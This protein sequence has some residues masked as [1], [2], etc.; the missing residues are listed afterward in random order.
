[1]PCFRKSLHRGVSIARAAV[2][3]LFAVLIAGCGGGGGGS[4]SSTTSNTPTSSA[5]TT[6][7][8]VTQQNSSQAA[9]AGYQSVSSAVGA[10]QTGGSAVAGVVSTGTGGLPNLAHFAVQQMEKMQ[11]IASTSGGNSVSGVTPNTTTVTCDSPPGGGPAGSFSVTMPGGGTLAPGD[12]MDATFDNCYLVSDGYTMNGSFSM[13]VSSL[14]GNPPT[15]PWTMGSTF[16]FSNLNL[17]ENGVSVTIN[18]NFTFSANTSDGVNF[19]T[20]MNGSSLEAQKSGGPSLWLEN[21]QLTMTDDTS[22]GESTCYGSGQVADSGLSGY[23]D[24]N[25]P[26]STAFMLYT[27]Q[28]YPSSGS[29]TVTGANNTS[30]TLTAISDT[31]VQLQVTESNGQVDSPVQE[32]WSSIAP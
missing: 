32:P 10:G 30:V 18:G 24:F 20:T 23:V 27:G 15:A 17:V 2:P 25:I 7:T 9:G 5:P 8:A 28:Q 29:M 6:E 16:S 21:F 22:N 13:V 4:A 26:S 19:N 12:T 3:A 31:T 14:L 11:S 1:M